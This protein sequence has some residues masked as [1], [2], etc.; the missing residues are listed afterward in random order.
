MGEVVEVNGPI[1][2]IREAGIRNGDQVTIGELGLVGEVIHIRHDDALVQVYESTESLRPGED[3]TG[4]GHPL[5]VE[6]GPGLLGQIFDGVQRPLDEI[7]RQSGEHVSR[8]LELFALDRDKSWHFVP[9]ESLVVGARLRGGEILGRV[10]ETETIEHR[11]LA[12]PGC[13]GEIIEH[14]P[15]GDYSIDEIVARVRNEAGTV[16]SLR[17]YHRWPVREPRPYR[18]R[19]SSYQPLLTGQR[20]LDTFFP[21]LKGGKAAVPGPFGAGKTIVQQQIARYRHSTS[22]QS[23]A[24]R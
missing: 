8:G 12:P 20:I 9:D 10:S 21:M 14:A 5:S 19:R 17:M 13:S 4:L 3:V 18:S 11:V 7:M 2:T 22:V 24:A 6:L 23:A 1:V 15:E 16:E